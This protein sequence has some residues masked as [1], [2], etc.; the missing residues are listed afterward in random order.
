M[1]GKKTG[2]RAAGTLNKVTS[3]LRS[4]LKS[5][6]AAELDELPQTL[7]ELPARERLELLIKLLPFCLPKVNTISGSYDNKWGSLGE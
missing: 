1:I 5:I 3:E 4:T 2:G 7:A 6:V